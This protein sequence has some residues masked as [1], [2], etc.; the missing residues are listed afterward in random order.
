MDTELPDH[1]YGIWLLLNTDLPFDIPIFRVEEVDPGSFL[2]LNS[3]QYNIPNNSSNL[4]SLD[5]LQSDI[6]ANPLGDWYLLE[7]FDHAQISDLKEAIHLGEYKDS[8]SRVMAQY[9][10][11]SNEVLC[12]ILQSNLSYF[13]KLG[14]PKLPV[15]PDYNT[16]ESFQ[17]GILLYFSLISYLE[18]YIG[19][20]PQLPNHNLLS[21][22]C[23]QWRVGL[24]TE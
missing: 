6:L 7:D 18:K 4:Y 23:V 15:L 8:P 3:T 16:I 5:F 12:K 14:G 20:V 21:W 1:L 22:E 24:L 11:Y 13:Q 2:L 17:K 19:D 9:I 10:S